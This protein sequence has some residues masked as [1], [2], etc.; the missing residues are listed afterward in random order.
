MKNMNKK[1]LF[2][3][4]LVLLFGLF[5][6]CASPPRSI[7]FELNAGSGESEIILDFAGGLGTR[8]LINVFK[9]GVLQHTVTRRDS[10]KFI[11][12]NGAHSIMIQWHWVNPANGMQG[13][14]TLSIPLNV[15]SRRYNVTVAFP[16][17]ILGNLSATHNVSN[18]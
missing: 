6:S 4:I 8:E 16:R 14:K 18:L 11:A 9:N 17:S 1:G 13:I 10:I 5:V 2:F 12:E 15:N 7:G 3:G